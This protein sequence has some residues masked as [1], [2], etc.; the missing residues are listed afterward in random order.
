MDYDNNCLKENRTILVIFDVLLGDL[1]SRCC[2]GTDPCQ[3][4]A[5]VSHSI[6]LEVKKNMLFFNTSNKVS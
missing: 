1:A 5:M 4:A 6:F 2:C 3:R